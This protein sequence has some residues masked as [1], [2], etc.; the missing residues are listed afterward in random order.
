MKP[1]SFRVTKASIR[2]RQYPYKLQQIHKRPHSTALAT[3]EFDLCV[4]GAGSG[5]IAGAVRG[6]DYGKKVAVISPLAHL[7]GATIHDGALSS[8]VMWQLSRQNRHLRSVYPDHVSSW[9]SMKN[10][11][12]ESIDIKSTHYLRQLTGLKQESMQEA[13]RYSGDETGGGGDIHLI[14]GKARFL[15][16][17]TVEVVNPNNNEPLRKIRSQYFLVSTGSS[18]RSVIS[19][20]DFYVEADGEYILTSDD[21]LS[22]NAMSDFPESLLIYG[23]GVIGCEFATIF[24]NYGVT[25]NIILFNEGRD[26]KFCRFVYSLHFVHEISD[27]DVLID[28]RLLFYF[29]L[30]LN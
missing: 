25:K 16:K 13:I 28:F 18:P 26:R 30:K 22:E 3:D 12:Q 11:V 2:R 5:G 19:K 9:Q 20:G 21:V 23:A 4:L 15:D 6:W 17:H 24:S 14:D 29:C 10:R 1:T 7:G 8:K 27:F